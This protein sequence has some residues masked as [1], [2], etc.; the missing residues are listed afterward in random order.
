[1]KS[2]RTS[3][4]EFVKDNHAFLAARAEK[5]HPTLIAYVRDEWGF[6]KGVV[7]ALSE[8]KVGWS[9]VH[10]KKDRD[11]QQ[12]SLVSL[13]LYQKLVRK[14]D[15]LAS[16]G[17]LQEALEVQNRIIALAKRYTEVAVE[18]WGV[19]NVPRWDR[20]KGLHNAFKSA[21]NNDGSLTLIKTDFSIAPRPGEIV[22]ADVIETLHRV[23]ARLHQFFAKNKKARAS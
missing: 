12:V 22:D 18:T 14:A 11:R 21:A 6:P 17:K 7:V 5:G 20:E 19:L 16:E 3:R 9:L 1:M 23:H 13:P 15:L 2:N 4:E 10:T 8:R